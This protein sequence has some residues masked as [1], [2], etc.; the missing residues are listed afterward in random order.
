MRYFL[1][2][3]LD[4]RVIGGQQLHRD[5]FDRYALVLFRVTARSQATGRWR[6]ND[7]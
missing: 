1:E 7:P 2:L 3:L 5:T 6:Q 4:Q